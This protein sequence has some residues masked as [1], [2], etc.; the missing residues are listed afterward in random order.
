MLNNLDKQTKERIKS[1]D[2]KF[3]KKVLE[4]ELEER[5]TSLVNCNE[6]LFKIEQGRARVLTE[7]LNL[8]P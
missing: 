1:G 3:L 4:Q 2:I 6:D 8:L 7:L 5:R